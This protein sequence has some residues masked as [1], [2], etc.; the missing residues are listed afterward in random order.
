L[1]SWNP[2]GLLRSR[3]LSQAREVPFGDENTFHLVTWCV[4]ESG[5]LAE[6]DVIPHVTWRTVGARFV[7]SPD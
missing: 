1:A 7:R 2:A 5:G 3:L 4:Y 6:L